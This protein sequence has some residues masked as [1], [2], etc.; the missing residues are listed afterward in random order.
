[1]YY[2]RQYLS[3]LKHENVINVHKLNWYFEVK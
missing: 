3:G 2:N 1:M